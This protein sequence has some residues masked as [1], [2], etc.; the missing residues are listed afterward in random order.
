MVHFLYMNVREVVFLV[1]CSDG[2]VEDALAPF[3]SML[4]E[5]DF[6][7]AYEIASG[8]TR[9]KQTLDSVAKK[10]GTL[11]QKRKEKIALRMALYQLLFLDRVPDYAVGHEM[12]ALAKKQL[13]PHFAKFLNAFLRTHGPK[14]TLEGLTL[15]EK[16]SYTPYF[17]EELTKAYGASMAATLLE[18]G[19]KKP[20]LFARE[21]NN[22]KMVLLDAFIDSPS[23][24]IQNP[25]QFEVYIALTSQLKKPPKTI[26]DLAASPGGKTILLHD[27]FPEAELFANDLSEKKLERLKENLEKYAIKA[28]LTHTSALDYSTDK[29][30]DLVVLDA[31]CSNSGCLYKCPEARWRLTKEHVEEAALLQ[32]KLLAKALQLVAP[33]GAIIYSTCSIL[34]QEN[35]MVTQGYNIISEKLIVPDE[36]GREGAYGALLVTE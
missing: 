33:G 32:K 5:R 20:P 1:L 10:Y 14:C 16:Q 17:A 24:Y 35:Q 11:P 2:F 34:P 8:V 12:V 6:S 23:Y 18:L 30:F 7:L 27:I 9:R 15:V 21:R 29:L 36:Q 22:M 26:I 13:S 31:P 28:T 4:S 3:K 19:N 25:A